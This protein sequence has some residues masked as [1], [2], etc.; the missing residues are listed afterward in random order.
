MGHDAAK[1]ALVAGS[2]FQ[3]MGP[4]V[5]TGK[6]WTAAQIQHHDRVADGK[7]DESVLLEYAYFDR[8]IR[9]YLCGLHGDGYSRLLDFGCG[10]GRVT[11]PAVQVGLAVV[12][13]DISWGMVKGTQEKLGPSCRSRAQFVV[14]DGTH[15]P[16]RNESF[17]AVVC[18]G[19]LHHIEDVDAGIREQVRVLRRRGRIFIGEPSADP[20]RLGRLLNRIA[21]RAFGLANS[22]RIALGRDAKF[23]PARRSP[24]ERPLS[25]AAIISV[26]QGGGVTCACRWYLHHSLVNRFVPLSTLFFLA[27]NAV[28]RRKGGDILVLTGKRN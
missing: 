26:L 1:G 7:Y 21:D 27:L 6:E 15:L 18:A 8:V 4:D 14:A 2:G 25:A 19:V 17:D 3:A 5:L 12:A 9:R 13:M 28:W 10:T 16:F 24:G 20:S 23:I 22:V 11:L